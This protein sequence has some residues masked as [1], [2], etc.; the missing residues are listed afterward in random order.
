MPWAA[1]R[2]RRPN[3]TSSLNQ[4]AH[5]LPHT[6]DFGMA[7][8]NARPAL[9]VSSLV[10]ARRY[11]SSAVAVKGV[12]TLPRSDASIEMPCRNAQ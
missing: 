12:D 11:A 9:T 7:C 3:R 10:N 1:E 2:C 5:T 6:S 4:E 8:S